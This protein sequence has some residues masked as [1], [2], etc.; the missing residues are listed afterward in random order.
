MLGWVW[1]YFS[2][3]DSGFMPN[4]WCTM[5]QRFTISTS[6]RVM[7]YSY[8]TIGLTPSFFLNISVTTWE[9]GL[10]I[11]L[12]TCLRVTKLLQLSEAE[13]IY[14][15]LII[16]EQHKIYVFQ[17]LILF[18]SIASVSVTLKTYFF[19]FVNSS[20]AYTSLVVFGVYIFFF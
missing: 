16:Y 15:Y 8:K 11:A 14:H 5:V 12:N 19:R 20:H 2:G 7:F 3:S 13:R 1:Y 10:F 17:L 18:A 4:G 6:R 9:V